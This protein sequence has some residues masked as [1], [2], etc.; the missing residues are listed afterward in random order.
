MSSKLHKDNQEQVMYSK[1]FNIYVL[2][3]GLLLIGIIVL[4]CTR[5]MRRPLHKTSTGYGPSS[6]TM[7]QGLYHFKKWIGDTK[8][9]YVKKKT[10]KPKRN[11]HEEECRRIFEEIFSRRFKSIR[12]AWLKNP[13]TGHNLELDGFNESVHTPLG[14]GLAFEYDGRQHSEYTPHFHKSS[15]DFVYQA[16][17]D[18]YKDRVCKNHGVLLI[19]IPHHVPY[20]EL[21]SYIR[22]RL[23]HF[24]VLGR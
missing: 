20:R 5:H 21:R 11:K 19:R 14:K 12:P 22:S 9:P 18:F 10:R 3:F 8:K 24:G 15:R 17:K 7:S 1:I 2:F 4:F 23:L 6:S 13:A 16:Q